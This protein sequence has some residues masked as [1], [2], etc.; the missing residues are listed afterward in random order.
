MTAE[1]DLLKKFLALQERIH[2]VFEDSLTSRQD[3]VQLDFGSTWTPPVDV[4]ETTNEWVLTAEIPGIE[5]EKVDLRISENTLTLRGER[6]LTGQ[7]ENQTYHRL[8]RPGGHF[9]R[10]FSL[11]EAVDREAVKARMEN[12]VLVVTLPK[13]SPRRRM[14]RVET[15]NK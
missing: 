10:K 13:K 15:G 4:F 11:P 2:S 7:L 6:E 1:Q 3:G 8:E 5:Q 12:G 14:I 9:E